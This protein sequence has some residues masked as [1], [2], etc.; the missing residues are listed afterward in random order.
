MKIKRFKLNALSAE[1][2]RQKEMNAIVGGTRVCTCSCY[3]EGNGGSPSI[4]NKN[5]NYA[6]GDYGG[7][8]YYGCNQ[9]M[10]ADCGHIPYD[11]YA[12]A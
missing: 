8:S 9:Y 2:L 11:P 7:E 6:L 12:T 4:D 5:A 1:G 3:W 10:K